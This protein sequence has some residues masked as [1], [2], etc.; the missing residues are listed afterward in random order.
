MSLPHEYHGKFA[1]KFLTRS[2]YTLSS[3]LLMC[4]F[5]NASSLLPD[6][7]LPPPSMAAFETEHAPLRAPC[8]GLRQPFQHV[9]QAAATRGLFG[10]PAELQ[11]VSRNLQLP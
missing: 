8:Q 11:I 2:R 10:P 9:R 7:P 6:A 1:H 3:D 4:L 5:V